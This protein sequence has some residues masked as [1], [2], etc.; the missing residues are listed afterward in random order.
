MRTRNHASSDKL[1]KNLSV[2]IYYPKNGE[3]IYEPEAAEVFYE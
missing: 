2:M 3:K 1:Y